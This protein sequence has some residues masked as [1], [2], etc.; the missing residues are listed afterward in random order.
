MSS[1]AQRILFPSNSGVEL[2]ARLDVPPGQ[3]AAFAIFAH[4]FACSKETLAASRIS[5]ALTSHGIAV[6]RFDFTG[7]GGSGG[8]FGNTGFSSNV[9]DLKAAARYLQEHFKAPSLLVGHSLGGAAVL[10]AA[11]DLPSVKAVVTIGAPVDPAHALHHFGEGVEKVKRE[12]EAAITIAGR[13]HNIRKSFIEDMES[14]SVEQ[15]VAAMHKPLLVMHAPLDDIVSVENANRI[16]KAAKHPKSFVSLDDADHMLSDRNH[17]KYVARVIAAWADRYL[18]I[19]RE[20][21]ADVTDVNTAI[22]S[23]TGEG[24]FQQVVRIRRHGFFADE[25]TNLGG[26]DSGPTPYQLLAASLASCT[27]M[28]IRMYADHKN[29]PLERVETKVQYQG[30]H[31]HACEGCASGQEM[32]IDHFDREITLEGDL[33]DEVRQKILAIADRCP[34]HLSLEK[35]AVVSTKLATPA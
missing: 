11:G 2:A 1:K 22:S 4:C 24:K 31:M 29:Y 19:N 33:S 8:D 25:P 20:G 32:R 16:F 9:E 3:I 26:L 21:D 34:V 5:S 13:T 17:A 15:R 6:L 7:L 28:T 14:Q 23:E 18:N 12:G 35:G 27:S 30:K 10:A